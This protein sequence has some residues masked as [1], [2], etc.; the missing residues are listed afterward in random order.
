M[1]FKISISLIKKFLKSFLVA[2]FKSLDRFMVFLFV[3]IT[4]ELILDGFWR[5]WNN[6]EIQDGG[7]RWPPFRNDYAI[8]TSC[9][10][11]T[12]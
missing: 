10:V 4:F 1:F 9:D 6:P 5:I 8:I 3:L 12:S 7:L 11:I 2:V